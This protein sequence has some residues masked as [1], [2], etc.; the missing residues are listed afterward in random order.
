MTLEELKELLKQSARKFHSPSECD[1]IARVY[2]EDKLGFR[3]TLHQWDSEI[4]YDQTEEI[5]RDAELLA[6]GVPV[7]YITGIQWFGGNIFKVNPSVLIPRPETEE[8]VE[9]IAD[10]LRLMN[11]PLTLL[12]IGTGSGCISVTL[13]LKFP[14]LNVV[15]TDVSAAAMEVA[16]YNAQKLNAEIK[17]VEDDILNPKFVPLQKFDLIVSNPPYIPYS[18]SKQMDH[19]VV[20]FEPHLALFAPE[21][22][23]LIFYSA[24]LNYSRSHLKPGGFVYC[25]IHQNFSNELVKLPEMNFFTEVQILSDL[26]GNARFFKAVLKK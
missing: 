19:H 25:E 4:P 26:S 13:K 3:L 18:E 23:P 21:H 7:Q 22:Q 8:L 9:I 1:A 5:K 14:A 11:M 15:A 6:Q 12:D 2:V 17:L 24:I 16:T 10:Q 20:S